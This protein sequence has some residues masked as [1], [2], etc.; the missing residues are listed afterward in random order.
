MSL[1]ASPAAQLPVVVLLHSSM[2]SQ[3]QWNKLV[4]R[5][6]GRYRFVAV[7]LL[8][9][10]RAP[11]PL[12]PDHFTLAHEADAVMASLAAHLDTDEPF[13]LVGHSYGGA[14]ALRLARELGS[15]VQSLCVFEPVAFHL[16]PHDA[17]ARADIAAVVCRI[18]GAATRT[19]AARSF[20]DY[21]NGAGTFDTLPEAQQARFA[22]QI[23][24]V[25]LDFQALLGE[26]ATLADCAR[27]AMPALVLSG[28][29][30]P[31]STRELAAQL[32]HAL[33]NATSAQVSGGHMAP[34]THADA[35]NELIASFLREHALESADA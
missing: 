20:I 2:S 22:A 30:S 17:P 6:S 25:K 16:L 1:T 15:R 14:T 3:S 19:D 26:P 9:Y 24:K 11:F 13:H 10:G 21:W 28:S 23:D 7:D 34:I 31:R 35:V 12:E 4:A 8:G 27:L 32:A 5:E 18:A 29:A 33:G